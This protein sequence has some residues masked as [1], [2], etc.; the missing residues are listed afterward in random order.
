MALSAQEKQQIR[1]EYQR[2]EKDTGTPEVQ[3]A[4]LTADINMLTEHFKVHSNDLHS[5]RGLQTK[6]NL[7][8]KLLTYLKRQ[9]VA[10]Y[11]DLIKRLGLRR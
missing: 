3:V 2:S 6:I 11:L 10:R 1:G 5:R 4:L 8:R 7:R 9:S